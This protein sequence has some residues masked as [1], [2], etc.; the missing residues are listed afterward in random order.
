MCVFIYRAK[1][2]SFAMRSILWVW[3]KGLACRPPDSPYLQ[4]LAIGYFKDFQSLQHQTATSK[5]EKRCYVVSSSSESV[6]LTKL[7][8]AFLTLRK[9]ME[10][11]I[12]HGKGSNYK[13]LR[14][15]K[16][17]LE[18]IGPGRL[19]MSISVTDYSKAKSFEV[20]QV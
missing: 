20:N 4:I 12:M 14:M 13:P 19:S 3:K 15:V 1:I 5:T 9:V 6:K 11:P 16:V 2:L 18:N 17:K 7:I 10:S 8:D